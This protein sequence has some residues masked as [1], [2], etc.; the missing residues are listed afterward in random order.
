VYEFNHELDEVIFDDRTNAEKLSGFTDMIAQA[1]KRSLEVKK[2]TLTQKLK[3]FAET[4]DHVKLLPKT[5]PG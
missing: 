3:R 4:F 1:A 5:Y 2:T